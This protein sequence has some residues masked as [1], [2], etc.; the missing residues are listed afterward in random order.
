M[1]EM[2]KTR[3]NDVFRAFFSSFSFV[4]QEKTVILHPLSR[5]GSIKFKP[6]QYFLN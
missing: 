6:Y 5:D 2:T 1:R 3:E 4:Y